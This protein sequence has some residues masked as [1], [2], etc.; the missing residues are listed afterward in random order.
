MSSKSTSKT[1]RVDWCRLHDDIWGK[2]IDNIDALDVLNFAATCGSW[3]S[4]CRRLQTRLLSSGQPTLL[5]SRPDHD[6]SRVENTIEEGTFGLHDVVRRGSFCVHSRFLYNKIWV[7]GKDDWLV[8]TDI[9]RCFLN[10]VNLITGATVPLPSCN[11]IN[12]DEINENY[13]LE[14]TVGCR[15]QCKRRVR[16]VVLCQTPSSSSGYVAIAQIS[17]G[18]I[19]YTTRM[20]SNWKLLAHPSNWAYFRFHPFYMDAILHKGKIFAVDGDGDVFAWDLDRHR[21]HPVIISAPDASGFDTCNDQLY[22]LAKSPSDELI[23]ISLH[24]K[25]PTDYKSSSRILQSE[26]DWFE[27][28][29]GMTLHRFDD[30]DGTWGQIHNFGL[31]NSVFVGLNYPFFGTWNGINPNMVYVA[32]LSEWDVIGFDMDGGENTVLDMRDYPAEDEARLPDGQSMRTPMWFRPTC[33][34]KGQIDGVHF[35]S[36]GAPP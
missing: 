27:E 10:L 21:Q 8:V 6:G 35:P 15:L 18:W 36:I 32:N 7:G 17:V 5:T 22:Y 2:I 20:D 11:T 28:I 13:D 34:S 23:L 31:G 30:R 33:P 3:S 25:V 24:G 1:T 12:V 26:N 4:V 14:N 19:A 29:G 9:N 16:R